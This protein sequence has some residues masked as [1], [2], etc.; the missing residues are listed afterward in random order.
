M[1]SR[2]S[3]LLNVTLTVLALA[4]NSLALGKGA[5]PQPISV[6]LRLIGHIAPKGRGQDKIYNPSLPVVDALIDSGPAAIPFL[7]S[8]LGD[9]TEI[10]PSVLDL[11]PRV[12]VGDVALVLLCDFFT[13]PDGKNTVAGLNWD[14]IL[15]RG[16]QD[17]PAWALL[18]DFVAKHGRRGLRHRAEGILKPH[19]G[20]FAWDAEERCFKPLK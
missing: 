15:E 10:D 18:E 2:R 4:L 1:T 6:D 17:G 16:N 20:R 12:R 5:P 13:R 11:W 3:T 19:H 7:L 14:G 8:K 9:E